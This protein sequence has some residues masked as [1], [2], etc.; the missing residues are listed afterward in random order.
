MNHT[1]YE[2]FQKIAPQLGK[3]KNTLPSWKYVN[4]Q[5]L[6]CTLVIFIYLFLDTSP[7]SKWKSSCLKNSCLGPARPETY[8]YC[9]HLRHSMVITATVECR[10]WLQKVNFCSTASLLPPDPNLASSPKAAH[11][12]CTPYLSACRRADIWQKNGN[13][14]F[15]FC[16][17]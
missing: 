4:E 15:S 5:V 9:S 17:L 7:Y 6:L 12:Q 8:C 1:Q 3:L 2:F 13:I 10:R 11:N 16:N 14:L